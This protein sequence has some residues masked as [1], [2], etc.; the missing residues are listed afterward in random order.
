MILIGRVLTDGRLIVRVKWDLTCNPT[1]KANAQLT[2][3]P[4]MSHGMTNF[5]KKGKDHRFYVVGL[6]P[7]K[8]QPTFY[9]RPCYLSSHQLMHVGAPANLLTVFEP[10]AKSEDGFSF[11]LVQPKS[12]KS[13]RRATPN[14]LGC[15][16]KKGGAISGVLERESKGG[17]KKR[18]A[19]NWKGE[20]ERHSVRGGL[21]LFF[22]GEGATA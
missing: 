22:G 9:T 15:C 11:N 5:D 10:C 14:R 17:F 13:G 4:H 18:R 16:D 20:E 7:S 19:E 8:Q 2:N 3:E 1:I 12:R 21:I 6:F